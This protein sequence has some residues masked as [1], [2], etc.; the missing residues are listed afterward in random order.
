MRFPE[1]RDAGE[2]EYFPLSKF[3]KGLDTGVS[4]NS[5]DRP[6]KSDEVG[7]LKTSAVTNGVLESIENKVVSK[8]SE[9]QRLK[10]P[11]C[12]DTIIISRMN[13]PALVGANAYIEDSLENIFLPDRLWA[14]KPKLGTS[15]RFIASILGSGRTRAALSELATGT[16]GSMKNITKS[17][18]LALQISAPSFPEQ[19]KIADCLLSIDEL[20]TVQSRKLESLKAHKKGLLQHLFPA[21]GE[22]VPKLRFPEFRD[23]GEWKEKPLGG[24]L[25]QHPDYGINAPAVPYSEELP[26]Y[27][28]ITD[29]SE[30][31]YFLRDQKVS[32]AKEV[33]AKNYLSEGDVALARTGASVG[34]SYRYRKEDGKLVFAGFLIRVKPEE[35]RL[36]SEFL[37]HFLS[38]EQY[39]R[40]VAFTSARSGQPGINGNEYAT[41]PLPLPSSVVEQQK[42]SNCLSS[43]DKLIAV[44]NQKIDTIKTHKRGLMQKL[45]PSPEGV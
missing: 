13:T 24:L 34:K 19:Q 23:A 16:S 21:E 38:T 1:F 37:F 4:V 5:G 7:I 42:I 10:E 14:A 45:F 33:T 32:V 27:L 17:D 41:L 31:G 26:T 18:V 2:W 11:V 25:L 9:Q 28:R 22:T 35:Q 15:M 12:E 39:W 44:Q 36:R 40:W 8:E 3:V 30:D 43:I 6:A 29:I 20:I